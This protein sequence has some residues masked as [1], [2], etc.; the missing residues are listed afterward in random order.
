MKHVLYAIALLGS[1]LA[2]AQGVGQLA[3]PYYVSPRTGAQHMDLSGSWA[4]SYT[5]TGITAPA[6][7]KGVKETF[8]TTVPNSVQWSLYKAGKLPHPYLHKN[9]EQYK[10]VDEKVWYYHKQVQIPPTD[11]L[12]FLCFEG[13]D[14]FARVWVNDSLVGQHEG[15]FGGPVVEISRFVKTG[16]PTDIVVEVKAGNWDD[17]GEDF[18]QFPRSSLGSRDYSGREGFKPQSP[19]KVMIPWLSAGGNG[20]EM[21]FPLGMWR[22]VRLELAD[23]YHLERPFL[24]TKSANQKQAVLDLSVEVFT[25]AQSL[26]KRLHPTDNGQLN[27]NGSGKPDMA[28]LRVRVALLDGKAVAYS[29]TVPLRLREGRNWVRQSIV[30]ANPKRWHPNGLGAAHRYNVRLTLLRDNR[31]IDQLSFTHGIRTIE[32]IPSAGPPL[33]NT[34]HNWQYVM[35]G[36]KL[37]V[38][39]INWMFV[40]PLLDAPEARYRW[41]LEAAQEAGI[42]MIRVNGSCLIESDTFYTICDELGIMVWQDFPLGNQTAPDYPQTIWEAQVAQNMFRL[43]NHPSLVAWCGGNEFNA[44]HEGKTT[45]IGIL[46]RCLTILDGTRPFYRTSPDGG[47]IHTYPDMDPAWY[48]K[49]YRDIPWIAETGIHSLP[50]AGVF[51]ET[52]RPGEF[53]DL[54]RMWDTTF[55]KT[56]PEFV[57]HFT[58]YGPAR[59]PKML[60]RASHIADVAAP[61]LEAICEASQIG[62]GEFYQVMSEK[63]QGNYPVTTGILPWVLMRTWPTAGIQLIDGFGHAGAPYYFLK[64]TYEPTHAA[65]DLPRLLWKAGERIELSVNVMQAPA[66]ALAGGRVTVRVFD[67]GFRPVFS[68]QKSVTVPA[69]PSVTA[70]P[71]GAY[72]IPAEYKDRFLFIVAELTDASGKLLSRSNY[73]PR[74]LSKLD[75][76]TDY[77]AYT[78]KPVDWPTLDKG[79][80]LKPTVAKTA[81]SLTLTQTASETISPNRSR[82]KIKLTNT[83]NLPAFMTNVDIDGTKRS[84]VASDN[85]FWLAPGETRDITLDVLWREPATKTTATLTASAWNAKPINQNAK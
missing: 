6:E 72:V 59:V 3:Q 62:A 54:G 16:V 61:T 23:R 42:Q 31:P 44:Y 53:T 11:G 83:G 4:L 1:Q 51:R 28:P 82:I 69:G 33:S 65:L 84:V 55:E 81:T 70:T 74:V 34:W 80:W 67:D 12:I 73:F 25:N 41:L 49:L 17:K 9:T 24:V 78:S 27:V 76:P 22:G 15:M 7:L 64:R 37:F 63:V 10:W 36:Q 48:G 14:Y 85:Y 35:N 5:N 32:Q 8:E 47:S 39:G 68:G 20:V 56:H 71:L 30:L 58:E 52:V 43:R 57:H 29:Q 45:V 19:G 75:D 46:E 21:F 79:P 2:F 66:R 18:E 13:I 50:E 38:K 77:D 40:D 26:P 60:S